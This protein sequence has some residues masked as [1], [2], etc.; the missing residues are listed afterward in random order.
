MR[1]ATLVRKEIAHR[2]FQFAA[3]LLSVSVVVAALGLTIASLHAF[4]RATAR[5][6]EEQRLSTEREMERLEDEVRKT[7]KGLGFN[8]HIFPEGQD[9]GEVYAQGYASK[10]MPESYARR[11][12]DGGIAV[13]N[14]ILPSLTVKAKWPEM[15]RTVLVVGVRGEIPQSHRG[16]VVREPMLNP[17]PDGHAVL[18]SELRKCLS[19]DGRSVVLMGRSFEVD[20]CEAERGSLDDITIWLSLKDAQGMFGKE[21]LINSILALECNCATVDRLGEI[22]REITRILPGVEVIE[23]SSNAIA[24]AES[25][26]QATKTAESQIGQIAADRAKLK[27]GRERFSILMGLILGA[28]CS[29]WIA[30]LTHVNV[31]Q[32]EHEIGTLLAVGVGRLSILSLFL[33]RA[34]A[35]GIGGALAGW[36]AVLCC[37]AAGGSL[38]EGVSVMDLVR[39]RDVAVTVFCAGVLSCTA[40]W[41]PALQAS[42][43]DPADT[44]RGSI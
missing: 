34:M 35:I 6:L 3:G 25:R 23:L 27:R 39:W 41:L 22:R 17:V 31:T 7:M 32:R 42:T 11:L 44:L 2:P 29:T 33:S 4:D 16:G 9:L 10:T 1:T 38:F 28:V 40:A 5:V 26:V 24:R 30:Y 21:G 15:E 13:I 12:A 8:I 43:R 37:G 14:H 18:G 19:P 36:L 20:K